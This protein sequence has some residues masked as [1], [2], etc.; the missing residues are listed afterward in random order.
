MAWKIVRTVIG[1][2]AIIVVALI[3]LDTALIANLLRKND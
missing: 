1:A 3:A 2:I